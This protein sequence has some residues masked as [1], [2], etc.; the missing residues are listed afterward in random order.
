VSRT[1]S[2]D[3]SLCGA[4]VAVVLAIDLAGN[5]PPALSGASLET[6]AGDNDLEITARGASPK[7]CGKVASLHIRFAFQRHR[8]LRRLSD[9][10]KSL[11][12]IGLDL[13]AEAAR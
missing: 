13:V 11:P 2:V 1:H 6:L 4:G 12:L 8:G 9:T 3:R 10:K 7:M 5:A